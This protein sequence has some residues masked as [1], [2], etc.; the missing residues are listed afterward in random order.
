MAVQKSVAERWLKVTGCAIVEG[1]G[2]SETS[3]DATCNPADTDE[4][5]GTI[6]IADAIDRHRDPR[7]RRPG[8]AARASRA[9][10]RSA[11]RR[12]WPATGSVRRKPPR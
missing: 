11:A 5:T 8:R 3:P 9:R 7:R 12:S 4:F 10:S 6:G 2:L 1:Y